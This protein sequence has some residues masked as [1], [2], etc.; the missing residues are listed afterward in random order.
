MVILTDVVD[1]ACTEL[2]IEFFGSKASEVMDGEG[3]E[4]QHVI[5]G[6]GVSFFDHH[7]FA[8]QQGQ[9]NGGPQAAG[10]AADDQTLNGAKEADEIL[11]KCRGILEDI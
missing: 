10:A 2:S 8:A 6:K 3:P 5:P 9:L 1:G 11:G 7:Y 4:V